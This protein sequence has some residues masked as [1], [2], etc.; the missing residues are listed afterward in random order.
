MDTFI[1]STSEMVFLT[2]QCAPTQM[3][4]GKL[5]L[6]LYGLPTQTGIQLSWTRPFQTKKL[7]LILCLILRIVSFI[8]LLMNLVISK[9]V[10]LS[11]TSLMLGRYLHQMTMGSFQMESLLILTILLTLSLVSSLHMNIRETPT[12]LHLLHLCLMLIHLVLQHP[13]LMTLHLQTLHNVQHLLTTSN[14]IMNLYVASSYTN[15]LILLS[16]PLR[17][18]HS[19]HA[20][21]LEAYS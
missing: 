2:S 10:K 21:T 18:Q 14:K 1:L 9:N 3:K 5:C 11:C 19:L 16:A 13:H 7:G 4:S 20:P 6:M 8:L 17:L 12:Q 15:Q